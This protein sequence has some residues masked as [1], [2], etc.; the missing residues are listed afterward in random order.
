MRPKNVPS[1]IAPNE[2]AIAAC[3]EPPGSGKGKAAIV[4]KV[5]LYGA[6][7]TLYTLI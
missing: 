7:V 5:V 3:N 1:N 6:G 4:V 2:S